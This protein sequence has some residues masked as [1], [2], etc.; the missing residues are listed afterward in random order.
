MQ[1]LYADAGRLLDYSD[2][3]TLVIAVLLSAQTTDAAVNQVT[4][5]LFRRWPDARSLAN[6][7]IDEVA[8]VIR[9]TGFFRVKA[10]HAVETARMI[11]N[12]FAGRVPKTMP[13]LMR[14]PGVGRKTANI[15]LTQ[16]F[17]AVGGIAVD[18]HVFRIAHR[19][20][21]VGQSADTP[22]KVEQAL[23]QI[24]PQELWGKLNHWWVLFGREFCS[25]Q[26]PR[27]A[28]CPLADICQSAV[29]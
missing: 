26:N 7:D 6:A 14:L 27:C 10:R 22:D 18:T 16:A 13:E 17:G 5:E 23:L 3:F 21:F 19:L 1:E 25:A 2:A 8:M 4:P 20:H 24:F 11:M 15:V 9:P 29:K 12:D 28:I